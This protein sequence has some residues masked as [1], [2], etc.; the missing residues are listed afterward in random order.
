[1]NQAI[2]L[3]IAGGVLVAAAA[4][5]VVAAPERKD[6]AFDFIAG[7]RPVT[8]DQVRQK[9]VS[10]GWS[11]VQIVVRGRYFMATASKDGR[12]DAF[13][14]DSLTG[15]LR[16]EETDD[17]ALSVTEACAERAASYP[18]RREGYATYCDSVSAGCFS[19]CH[20]RSTSST[21]EGLQIMPRVS[22]GLSEESYAGCL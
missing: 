9:L 5:L 8:E 14:V 18:D 11:D 6:P 21:N 12:S 22:A 7:N 10:D 1:M 20:H 16:G 15:R 19:Q 17:D 3:S 2:P 13:A 4:A